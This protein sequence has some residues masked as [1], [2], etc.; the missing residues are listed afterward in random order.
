[1]DITR[2][3]TKA[4]YDEAYRLS[5]QDPE[6]FWAAQAETFNWRKKWDKVLQW[7]FHKP[8]VKWFIG[9]K[10]NIT[11]NCLDRHLEKRG[12]KLA[13]IW[14]PNDPRDR[15]IRYTYRELHEKVCQYANVLKRNGAKKGDRICIYMPMIPELTIAV[16][17]CARIG[18]IHS[19]VFA[20]FSARSIA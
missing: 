7:D 14:E 12:N 9:G 10:L 8:E 3:R 5:V 1:M 13:L 20:G 15:F 19:V 17:A 11:E 6:A 2:I 16:L 18:A 4:D